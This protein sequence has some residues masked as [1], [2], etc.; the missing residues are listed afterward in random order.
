LIESL[1]D[2]ELFEVCTPAG[3]FRMTRAD[4]ERDFAE[5][6]ASASYRD[7]GEYHYPMIPYKAFRFLQREEKAARSSAANQ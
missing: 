2:Q 4:F 7:L 3:K 1:A 6:A 5:V